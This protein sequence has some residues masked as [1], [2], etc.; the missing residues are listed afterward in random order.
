MTRWKA[1][2]ITQSNRLETVEFETPNSIREDAISQCMSMYGAKRVESCNPL[3]ESASS[4]YYKKNDE[5]SSSESY[6]ESSSGVDTYYGS[7]AT[8]IFI[9][10]VLGL[11]LV[12]QFWPFF[13]IGG[14][15]YLIYW[16]LKN[17]T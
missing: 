12:V 1:Y 13:L 16:I 14:I 17:L 4:G 15:I 6:S 7:I 2:I 5:S 3:S 11:I 8:L 9:G 10:A